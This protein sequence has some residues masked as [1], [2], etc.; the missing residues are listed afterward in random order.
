MTW[1]SKDSPPLH[2]SLRAINKS[3]FAQLPRREHFNRQTRLPR[4]LLDSSTRRR[5]SLPRASRTATIRHTRDG[6]STRRPNL[7]LIS[8]KITPRNTAK[9]PDK[10]NQ[11]LDQ[12]MSDRRKTTRKTRARPGA[13][14]PTA[15]SAGVSKKIKPAERKAPN[16]AVPTGPANR[17][18]KVQVS[19]L[20]RLQSLE[21]SY[22]NMSNKLLASRCERGSDQGM[23][24]R[25]TAF[26]WP[27]FHPIKRLRSSSP[28]PLSCLH[29]LHFCSMVAC[30]LA[31][32]G[33][34][35]TRWLRPRT[36]S[37]HIISEQSSTMDSGLE[38]PALSQHT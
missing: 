28:D 14:V 1:Y 35:H 34:K 13:K 31:L 15:P 12:I 6:N 20:V 19:N 4:L 27:S 32:Y 11:S 36:L 18:S 16:K 9:M 8:Y 26:L 17:E 5:N 23:L 24:M 21:P 38:S 3:H 22:D 29:R 25:R 7:S 33:A 37:L 2:K 10:L 30:F